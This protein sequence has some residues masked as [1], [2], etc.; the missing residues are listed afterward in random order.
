[1]WVRFCEELCTILCS[2]NACQTLQFDPVAKRIWLHNEKNC[3]C[4]RRPRDRRDAEWVLSYGKVEEVTKSEDVLS[5]HLHHLLRGIIQVS[6]FVCPTV[7]SK[8]TSFSLENPPELCLLLDKKV[9]SNQKYGF[10]CCWNLSVPTIVWRSRTK[11][12]WSWGMVLR[13]SGYWM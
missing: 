1:M 4:F 6:V 3:Y 8:S 10:F 2:K 9:C 7:L 11:D 12:Q 13:G 5:W